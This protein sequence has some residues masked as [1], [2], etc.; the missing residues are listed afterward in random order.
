MKAVTLLYHDVVDNGNYEASGFNSRDA[1][2][3]KLEREEFIQQLNSIKKSYDYTAEN[4]DNLYAGITEHIPF[5]ITFDDGGKSFLSP[6]ADILEE[7]G[8]VGIFFISTDYID[9]DGFMSAEELKLLAE[10][11][12]IIGSHS[13]SHPKKISKL[14]YEQ[15]LDEWCESKYVLEEIIG[16]KITTA[17]VPGGFLSQDIEKAAAEAGYLSLFT[18]EPQKQTYIVDGCI[19]VGRYSITQGVSA[20]E[21]VKLASK[22]RT[23]LQTWQYIFWNMKKVAKTYVGPLYSWVRLK[24][25]N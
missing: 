19:I 1:D 25:F 11:G 4:L 21:V 24:K 20:N 5:Y 7:L 9:T 23:L 12:H 8:W 6:I 22:T 17:S 18:S 14:T 2:F 3:Y 15:I 10:R 16:E 13:S